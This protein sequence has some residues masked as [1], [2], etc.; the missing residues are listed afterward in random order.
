[1][2]CVFLATLGQRPEAITMALDVLHPRYRYS[3]IGILHTDTD[4]SGIVESYSAL[5]PLLQRAYDCEIVS[6]LM[7]TQD[8]QAIVD[9]TDAYTAEH[10]FHALLKVLRD[11]RARYV[12]VHM[13][14]SGGRKAMSIYATLAAS[15][16]FGEHDRVWTALAAP[17]VMQ[18]GKFH[19][20][21]GQ[22]PLF[23]VVQLPLL[24]S[25]LLPAAIADVTELTRQPSPR[26]RFLAELTKQETL[27][28][29]AFEQHPYAS[30]AELGVILGKSHRTIE[31]QFRSMYGKLQT[32]FDNKFED[33]QKRQILLDV[34]IGRV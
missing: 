23:N 27:L 34:L 16:L 26:Q 1:M 8:G 11:Y 17:S 9:I 14:V 31:N 15:M 2:K 10:Y 25:R 22:A 19:L 30:N 12:P 4:R 33:K 28:A 24:P 20:E 21:R 29:Q 32:Y 7:T 3:E 18:I 13:L 6:H 5:L